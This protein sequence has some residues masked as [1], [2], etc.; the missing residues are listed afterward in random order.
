MYI[1]EI[2]GQIT[3]FLIKYETNAP[4]KYDDTPEVIVVQSRWTVQITVLA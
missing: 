3:A 1:G 4:C 2:K